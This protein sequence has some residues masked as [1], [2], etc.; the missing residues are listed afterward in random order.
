MASKPQTWNCSPQTDSHK[1]I[2]RAV[3][4]ADFSRVTFFIHDHASTVKVRM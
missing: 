4:A 1:Q 3:L 2:W